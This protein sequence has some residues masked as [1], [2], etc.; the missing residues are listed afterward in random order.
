[1]AQ[2]HELFIPADLDVAAAP[3][4]RQ[5]ILDSFAAKGGALRLDIGGEMP[6]Q[7]ALQLLFATHRHVSNAGIR[8]DYGPNVQDFLGM[9]DDEL[10][11]KA[12]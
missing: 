6:T 10:E 2:D 11:T 3:D 9:A 1:M 7:V 8:V 4:L 12:D 5:K